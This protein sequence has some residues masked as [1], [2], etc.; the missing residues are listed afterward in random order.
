M[1]FFSLLSLTILAAAGVY[2]ILRMFFKDYEGKH[3][4]G[5]IK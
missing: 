4:K 1:V 3:Y 2:H 5:V